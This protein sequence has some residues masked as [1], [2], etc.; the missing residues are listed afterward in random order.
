MP[1]VNTLCLMV[2]LL[3]DGVTPVQGPIFLRNGSVPVVPLFSY[4]VFNNGTLLQIPVNNCITIIK[5]QIL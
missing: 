3:S 5:W 1:S 2:F 4:P